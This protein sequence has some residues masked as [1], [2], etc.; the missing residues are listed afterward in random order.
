MCFPN[1]L[2][3]EE[4]CQDDQ[5]LSDPDQQNE[6]DEWFFLYLNYPVWG[7]MDIN[8]TNLGFIIQSDDFED[9]YVYYSEYAMYFS[10]LFYGTP[11]NGNIASLL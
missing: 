4:V 8:T 6:Q 10:H 3:Y 5:V 9:E 7:E 1:T 11:I 2:R